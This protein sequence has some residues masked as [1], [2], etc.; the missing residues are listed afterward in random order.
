MNYE[1]GNEITLEDNKSYL[2]IDSFEFNNSKYLYL[3]N[4]ENKEA[5]LVKVINDTLYEIEDDNEFN[6]VLNEVVNKNMDKIDEL[7]KETN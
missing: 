7:L 1:I 6:K 5:S 3:F 4:E 2:I